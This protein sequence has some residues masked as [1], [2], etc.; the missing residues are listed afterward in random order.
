[1]ELYRISHFHSLLWVKPPWLSLW[2]CLLLWSLKSPAFWRLSMW[3]TSLYC[4]G[5]L[6]STSL[7]LS[8]ALGQLLLSTLAKLLCDAGVSLLAHCWWSWWIVCPLSLLMQHHFLLGLLVS[9]IHFS[10]VHV[11]EPYTSSFNVYFFIVVRTL[12]IRPAFLI[13]S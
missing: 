6:S 3:L 1:M 10:N 11:P 9:Y 13:N 5:T 7:S 4:F 2:G 12:N 8:Q